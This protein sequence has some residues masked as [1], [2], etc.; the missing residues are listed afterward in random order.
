MFN[1]DERFKGRVFLAMVPNGK[2]V[3]VLD[4]VSYA[5]IERHV[6]P[7]EA[8]VFPPSSSIILLTFGFV[9][10]P[11]MAFTVAVAGAVSVFSG[12]SAM[13]GAILSPI[14]GREQFCFVQN[15]FLKLSLMPGGSYLSYLC[16]P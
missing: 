1:V 10:V 14:I 7:T 8:V 6:R 12:I 9:S 2:I 15:V 3:W 11:G 16:R 5:S 13:E 4:I